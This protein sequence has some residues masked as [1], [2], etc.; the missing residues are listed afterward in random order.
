MQAG[1][2]LLVAVLAASPAAPPA[3]KVG[4]PVARPVAGP[5][6]APEFRINAE[7]GPE[8]TREH[9]RYWCFVSMTAG[10]FHIEADE[11]D[12]YDTRKPDGTGRR[13]VEARGNVV[14][15]RGEERIAGESMEMDLD[16]GRATLKNARGFVQ[17]GV[18]LEAAS[19]ERLSATKYVAHHAEFTSCYQP[20]PRWSFTTPKATFKINDHVFAWAVN[21]K[22]K[23]TETPIFLPAFYY[24]IQEDQRSTGL[25]FPQIGFGD[26]GFTLGTGFFWAMSRSMDQT[27]QYDYMS[28]AKLGGRRLSHQFRYLR[29]QPSGGTF[30]TEIYW[31]NDGQSRNYRANWSATQMLLFGIK[32]SLGVS[33]FTSTTFQQRLE[34]DFGA[35]TSR[36]RSRSLSLTRTLSGH[37]ITLVADRR[38][39]FFTS[40]PNGVYTEVFQRQEHLPSLRL[41]H[42]PQRLGGTHFLWQYQASAED[43]ANS[44]P[45]STDRFSRFDFSPELQRPFANSFLQVTPRV[46]LRVTRL[47]GRERAATDEEPGGF[48][49][50]PF[51]RRYVEGR[52]EMRGPSFSRVFSNPTHLYSDRIKHIIEPQVTLLRRKIWSPLPAGDNPPPFYGDDLLPETTELQ[53]GL[54]QRLMAKRPGPTG[55]LIPYEFLRLRVSQTY[56]AIEA[57]SNFDPN[58]ISSR[59]DPTFVLPEAQKLSPIRADLRLNPTAK[60]STNA[61]VEYSVKF[62]DVQSLSLGGNFDLG[63]LAVNGGWSRAVHLAT[64]VANRQVLVDTVQGGG[65]LEILPGKLRVEASGAYDYL[66]KQLLNRTLALHYDVQCCGFFVQNQRFDYGAQSRNR[67]V[68]QILL[69]NIGAVGTPT[70]NE[71]FG[72]RGLGMR[73]AGY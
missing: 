32:A 70:A 2:L 69:A 35:L 54:V 27:V 41:L 16:S 21:F 34:Q 37:N 1:F 60:L 7:C 58:Y 13:R 14:F 49:E 17:P 46:R 40:F 65:R 67:W 18:F 56:Y 30:D 12:F 42:A 3:V 48:F 28:D 20:S 51:T 43:L 45:K 36:N 25:L 52:L 71:G 55:K 26:Q 19:L 15:I 38:D 66:N 24:P 61:S 39:T 23:D 9:M 59:F 11:A 29:R 4:G 10:D 5:E 47:G 73:G 72:P 8:G 44:D 64:N 63:R 50:E 6:S 33:E 53:Y 31:P 57:A 68:F 62:K 22:V